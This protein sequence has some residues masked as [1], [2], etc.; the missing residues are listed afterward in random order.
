MARAVASNK[1]LFQELLSNA[2][3]FYLPS[4]V[5]ESQE[6][7]SPLWFLREHVMTNTPVV[8]R[9]G[10]NHWPAIEKWSDEYLSETLGNNFL[11]RSFRSLS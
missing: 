11:F 7:P 9:G 1:A 5:K 8:I 6:R 4:Q 2:H 3:D 10:V